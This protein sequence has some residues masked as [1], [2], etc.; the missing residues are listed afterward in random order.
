MRIRITTMIAALAALAALSVA[1]TTAGAAG[2]PTRAVCDLKLTVAL[3]PGISMKAT[4]GTFKSTSGAMRC[5][6]QLFGTT[7]THQKTGTLSIAGTYG[8]D[9]C[10]SGKGKGTF[11]AT[12]AGKR[13][14]GSFTYNRAGELGSFTG[15]ARDGLG[16][17]AAIR[18][19]FLFQPAS[20]QNCVQVKVTKATVTGVAVLNG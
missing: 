1:A 13:A 20:G 9:T 7:L 18:G 8:P 2:K 15:T 4:S 3:T 12:L 17:T 14:L 5:T 11:S 16:S 10:A 6:G 19:G